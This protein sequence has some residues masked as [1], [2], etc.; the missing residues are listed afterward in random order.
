MLKN[1]DL[2]GCRVLCNCVIALTESIGS[3]IMIKIALS[4]GKRRIVEVAV[5]S[6]NL[7]KVGS[8]NLGPVLDY[9]LGRM[10]A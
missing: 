2:A 5:T 10:V 9:V 8:S 1:N 3:C 7:L 4:A 6:G